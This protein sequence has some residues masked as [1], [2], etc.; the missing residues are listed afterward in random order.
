MNKI[1]LT[2]KIRVIWLHLLLKKNKRIW[3]STIFKKVIPAMILHEQYR[4]CVTIFI[5]RP[6]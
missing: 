1:K 3:L 6:A 4:N 5:K 2:I